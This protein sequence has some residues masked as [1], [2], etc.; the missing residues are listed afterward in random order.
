MSMTAFHLLLDA[1]LTFSQ[2]DPYDTGHQDG[3]PADSSG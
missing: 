2:N 1:C 3:T